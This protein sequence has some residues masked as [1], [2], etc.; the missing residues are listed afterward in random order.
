M[1]MRKQKQTH[2][3]REQTSGY[4]RGEGRGEGQDKGMGLRDTNYYILNK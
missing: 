3:Y 4:Q 1:Y 2:R